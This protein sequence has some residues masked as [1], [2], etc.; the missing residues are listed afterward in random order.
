MPVKQFILN[1][2][3]QERDRLD[4]YSRAKGVPATQVLRGLI[5]GLDL[6]GALKEMQ[7]RAAA[8]SAAANE[9]AGHGRIQ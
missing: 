4:L 1:L 2:P 3:E 6:D 9:E 8:L 7:I 5:A